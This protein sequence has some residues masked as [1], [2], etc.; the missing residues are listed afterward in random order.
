[1]SEESNLSKDIEFIKKLTH[2][3]V[4]EEPYSQWRE[5]DQVHAMKAFENIML[6]DTQNAAFFIN[7]LAKLINQAADFEKKEASN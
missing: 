4:K 7:D 6:M 5:V 3:I 2:E 1:M